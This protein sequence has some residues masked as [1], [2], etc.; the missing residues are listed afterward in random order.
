M[1]LL[2]IAMHLILISISAERVFLTLDCIKIK[3][4]DAAWDERLNNLV[5][6]RMYPGIAETV[7]L[8]N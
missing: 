8:I 2:K 5:T 1:N 6:C 7:N 3:S 4:C